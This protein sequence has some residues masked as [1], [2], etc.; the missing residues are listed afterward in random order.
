[1]FKGFIS[2]YIK[3]YHFIITYFTFTFQTTSKVL[4][5]P[6]LIFLLDVARLNTFPSLIVSFG[7][8]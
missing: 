2:N 4:V 3:T 5:F 8:N 6:I 7:L 1:M